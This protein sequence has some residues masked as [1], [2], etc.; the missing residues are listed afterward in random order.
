MVELVLLVD[1]DLVSRARERRRGREPVDSSADDG[2][3]HAGILTECEG[4]AATARP[5]AGVK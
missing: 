2:N 4:R 1:D 5:S 3:T